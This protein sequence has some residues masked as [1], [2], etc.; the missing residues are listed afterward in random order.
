MEK[1]IYK[2]GSYQILRSPKKEGLA[3]GKQNFSIEYSNGS[4]KYKVTEA[5]LNKI[6][7]LL[8]KETQ[9]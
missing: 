5:G 4:V 8:K 3:S 1:I 9:Q 2:E 7:C 6:Y